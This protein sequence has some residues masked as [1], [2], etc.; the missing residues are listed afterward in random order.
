L[1]AGT[2]IRYLSRVAL[3]VAVAA[4]VG[5]AA[6]AQDPRIEPPRTP[7]EFWNAV[8]FELDTGRFDVAGQYLKAFLA[9]NPTD[10][11]YLAI[12]KDRGMAAF[13]R[14]RT[15]I[16]WSAD[17]P[18]DDEARK[19]AE[20]VIEK[21]TAALRKQLGDV[22]RINRFIR[23][24][25]ASPE[26]RAYAIRELQRSGA[27]AMPHLLA[28]MQGD[29]DPAQRALLLDVLP[30]LPQDTI[31]PLLASTDMRD[32][33]L[34]LLLLDALAARQDRGTLPN[35]AETD[36]LPT[37]DYLAA[38]PKESDQVRRRARDTAALLRTTSPSRLPMA[39]V[40]LT[41]AAEKF[42][43]HKA[44][45]INPQAVAVW[46]WEND[47]LVQ[48]SATASQAEEYLGLRYARWA[49]ELDPSYQPAQ[50]VFLSLAVEKAMERGGPDKSLSQTAPDVHDLLATVY[51][52]A[53][54]QTLDRALTDGRTAVALGVVRAL[55][56]RA[57]VSAAR[58]ERSRP[59]VLVR[60]LD[61]PDRR[62]QIAA[63]DALLRLPKNVHTAHARVV[64]V[65]RRA[66]AV[67][68]ETILPRTQRILVCHFQPIVADLMAGA[69]RAAGYEAVVVNTGREAMR[70]LKEA[71]DI[72][73][74]ILDADL[75]YP[76]LPDTIASLRYDVHVGLLPVRIV[77]TPDVTPTTVIVN[78]APLPP[79]TTTA[80]PPVIANELTARR[81]NRL[82]EGYRQIAV[83]PGPVTPLWVRREFGEESQAEPA[84]QARDGT[85]SAPFTPEERKGYSYL[86][87]E[88]FKR[89]AT[90]EVPGYDV[91]PAERAI[92]SALKV[93]ELTRPAIE[94]TARLT[95]RDAQSDLA[96]LVLDASRPAEVRI[97][98]AEALVQ[99]V[100]RIGV[101]LTTQQ[102][103][104]LLDLMPTIQEPVFRAR[105]AAVV[106][107]IQQTAEQSGLRM[108]RFAPA[109]PTAPPP[110][111]PEP[112][113]AP[114][115]AE[116]TKNQ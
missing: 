13:L 9:T 44:N 31:A 73:G 24:L 105:V 109:L 107:S 94:A 49:L 7:A 74:I 86:A 111:A 83:V 78:R 115:P 88:W 75:P 59:G 114:P 71:A 50:A 80:P 53:L 101:T 76:L 5:L 84:A 93:E 113:P 57:E 39:K 10:Q 3:A 56:E 58:T 2:V 38:S 103:Q 41:Q 36:P 46:R 99:N 77:Y 61:Y 45:F 100:R 35:R 32:P 63:A 30:L 85:A 40:A 96:S 69:V 25:Q 72:D 66:L 108:Q 97:L 28:A 21:A 54:I 15:V 20:L 43:Q 89:M 91:R 12:E 70:R 8:E 14:L 60:A 42:Y 68:A 104:S 47:R 6:R 79:L 19:N 67:E 102:M 95:T 98:A 27:L 90:G 64:E 65:L 81:L 92:R 110:P 4:F 112:P 116:P 33:V 48:Y 23:N 34:K 29:Q 82:I 87:I 37:L 16:Q 62:V 11:D 55:G 52:G 51:P 17:K 22:A 106:G 1:E 18:T 26:E